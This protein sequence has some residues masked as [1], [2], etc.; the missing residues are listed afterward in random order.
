MSTSISYVVRLSGWCVLLIV[1]TAGT[2]V[3][4]K[5]PVQPPSAVASKT[6]QK[7]SVKVAVEP[8][9][10]V[11]GTSSQITIVRTSL[12]LAADDRGFTDVKVVTVGGKTQKVDISNAE[13]LTFQVPPGDFVG[14]VPVSV[15]MADGT[16]DT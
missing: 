11:A 16:I 14:H 8:P 2:L 3:A 6:L 9:S 1:L 12:P 15:Q 5:E 10:A 4:Q 7:S 13:R